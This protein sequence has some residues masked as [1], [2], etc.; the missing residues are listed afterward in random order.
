MNLRKVWFEE[1]IHFIASSALMRV[2]RE[3]FF[4]LPS[5]V[6]FEFC[7]KRK[8]KLRNVSTQAVSSEIIR[9]ILGF[10]RRVKKN[11]LFLCEKRHRDRERKI[12]KEH[13]PLNGIPWK[14]QWA[15]A[16]RSTTSLFLPGSLH[17]T[18]TALTILYATFVFL[19]D[20]ESRVQKSLCI[21]QKS[22]MKLEWLKSG[23]VMKSDESSKCIWNL[24]VRQVAR[25]DI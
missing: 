24:F 5:A 18:Y 4:I 19:T 1:K 20:K 7:F 2:I 25:C 23:A 9:N 21:S 12:G 10:S 16:M 15:S 3:I 13:K 14:I 11:L 8:K 17:H 6:I 22:L